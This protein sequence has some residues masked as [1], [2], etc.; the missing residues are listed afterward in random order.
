LGFSE[1]FSEKEAYYSL[2]GVALALFL[3]RI[4]GLFKNYIWI[5]PARNGLVVAVAI[6]A[7]VVLHHS[8]FKSNFGAVANPEAKVYSGVG[9]DSVVLFALHEG[10]EFAIVESLEG[11]WV[12]SRLS[13]GKQG[14]LKADGVILEKAS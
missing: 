12:R 11:D 6:F 1:P 4:I 13:D 5:K 10:V 2:A 14:W 7:A 3:C 8:F 9:T